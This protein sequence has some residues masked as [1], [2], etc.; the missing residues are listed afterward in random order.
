MNTNHIVVMTTF[1]KKETGNKLVDGLLSKGLAACIQAFPVK[2]CYTWKGSVCKDSETLLFIKTKA[3]L[4]E[5]VQKTILQLHDYETPEIISVP[6]LR[7]S[8]AYLDWID[9]VTK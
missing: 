4:F 9:S 8:K 2:S 3:Q 5:E 6:M 1:S 7:G